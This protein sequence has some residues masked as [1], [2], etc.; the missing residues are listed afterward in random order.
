MAIL[1]QHLPFQDPPKFTQIAIFGLKL[2]HLA[3]MAHTLSGA[4]RTFRSHLQSVT[5]QF[6]ICYLRLRGGRAEISSEANL[7]VIHD[8]GKALR[9]DKSQRIHLYTDYEQRLPDGLFSNQKSK[10]G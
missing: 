7:R 4:L 10:F 9:I 2:R 8:C 3:T 1:Y 6:V 5:V